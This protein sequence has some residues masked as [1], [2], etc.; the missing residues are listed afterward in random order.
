MLLPS[1]APSACLS[2]LRGT[3]I[4]QFSTSFSPLPLLHTLWLYVNILLIY[5]FRA[6]TTT[7]TIQLLSVVSGCILFH[8]VLLYTRVRE[9]ARTHTHVHVFTTDNTRDLVIQISPLVSSHSILLP[10]S[11]SFFLSF[12]N[13][14]LPTHMHC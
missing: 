6:T 8:T 4:S 5:S 3:I 2:A 10:H 13:N 11:S 9:C 1:D 7:T 14:L 12:K